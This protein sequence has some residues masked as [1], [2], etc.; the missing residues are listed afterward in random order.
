MFKHG[1][2]KLKKRKILSKPREEI[3]DEFN[4]EETIR[5]LCSDLK[6]YHFLHRSAAFYN[7]ISKLKATP[8]SPILCKENTYTFCNKEKLK[9][10][11]PFMKN[12]LAPKQTND[13]SFEQQQKLRK[14]TT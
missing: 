14:L 1:V 5:T 11:H 4:R 6:K 3:S 7:R 10:L 2:W 8:P 9:V 13:I 12:I